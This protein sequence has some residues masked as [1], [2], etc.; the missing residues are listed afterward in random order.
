MFNVYILANSKWVFV[1]KVNGSRK[2]VMRQVD[3]DRKH[4]GKFKL[5]KAA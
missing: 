2:N 1:E 4:I 3:P 5:R